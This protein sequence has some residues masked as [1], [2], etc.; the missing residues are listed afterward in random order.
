M[1]FRPHDEFVF[2]LAVFL[3]ETDTP[4]ISK[5]ELLQESE[6]LL[7]KL[8]EYYPNSGMINAELADLYYKS[9]KYA[10]ALGYLLKAK[11]NS[12]SIDSKIVAVYHKQLLNESL[13]LSEDAHG[14]YLLGGALVEAGEQEKG[15]YFLE[16]AVRYGKN[17]RWQSFAALDLA[18]A[19]KG[20]DDKLMIEALKLA[21][22]LG[23]P[24][25]LL[26]SYKQP[27]CR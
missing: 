16:Q 24:E 9:E 7:L 26:A 13:D 22:D 14:A 25:I 1:N 10:S 19:C 5:M 4:S 17:Q 12:Y 3:K 11:L 23:N 2:R 21:S 27:N 20:I 18:D 15:L 8:C 6:R